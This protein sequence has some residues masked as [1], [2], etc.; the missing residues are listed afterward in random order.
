MHRRLAFW[1]AS[2]A[3]GPSIH[4]AVFNLECLLRYHVDERYRI[5]K[6]NEGDG[7]TL[8]VANCP[9]KY[10]REI[11]IRERDVKPRRFIE[12]ESDQKINQQLQRLYRA[13]VSF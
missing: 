4:D 12:Q 1:C 8:L 10:D 13:S 11:S 2:T 5:W 6:R 9:G 3:A 7:T